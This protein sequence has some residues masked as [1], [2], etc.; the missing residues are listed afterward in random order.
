LQ[1]TNVVFLIMIG[2]VTFF[3]AIGG[4]FGVMNTMFAAI[5]SRIKDIGVLRI[6]G[7]A[8]WQILVSFFLESLTIALLGGA[9][10][11]LIGYGIADGRTAT[12]IVSG[13]GGGGGKSIILRLVVDANI[14]GG[15][16]LLALFMGILGGVLPSLKAMWVRPLES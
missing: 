3:L 2:V 11:C 1:S 16:L 6:L 5:S 12:S 4:I 9:L 13:A 14:L 15:G 10:G 7:Y 8:R